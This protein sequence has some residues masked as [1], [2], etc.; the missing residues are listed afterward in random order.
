MEAL[1]QKFLTVKR[2]TVWTNEDD[3]CEAAATRPYN[4]S[5]SLPRK[6]VPDNNVNGGMGAT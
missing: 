2:G 6:K 5:L 3:V 1:K 4:S